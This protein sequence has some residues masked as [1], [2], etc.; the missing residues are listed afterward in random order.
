MFNNGILFSGVL[1]PKL[2]I[3]PFA[4]CSFTNLDLLIQYSAHFDCIIILPFFVLEIFES[5]FPAF[6][7]TLH[8]NLSWS[9]YKI[10]SIKN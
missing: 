3:N 2:L 9:F 10:Q 6:F 1:V 7:C 4:S 8:N 5:K